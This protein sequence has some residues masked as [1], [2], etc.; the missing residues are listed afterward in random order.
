MVWGPGQFNWDIAAVKDTVTGGLSENAHLEF[1]AE[2][3]NAFNHANFSNPGSGLSDGKPL[4]S[5]G[6]ISS[7]TNGP[8]VVQFALK[9][10][11]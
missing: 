2:F 5:Y 6:V 9:Y 7:T 8:R 1:R 10:E 4:A 11:F 3:F